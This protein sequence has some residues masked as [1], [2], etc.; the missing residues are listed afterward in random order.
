MGEGLPAL[1]TEEKRD[2]MR[3][4]TIIPLNLGPDMRFSDERHT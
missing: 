2:T 4:Q 3:K 1:I